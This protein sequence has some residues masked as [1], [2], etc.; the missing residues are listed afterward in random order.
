MRRALF[1]LT[2]LALIGG[3]L[4]TPATAAIKAG[5]TCSKLNQVSVSAGYKYTCIKSG[6]KLV[7]SK[8]V[9]VAVSLPTQSPTAS[10]I[11]SSTSVP[12][13]KPSPTPTPSATPVDPEKLLEAKVNEYWTKWRANLLN[14]D[15]RVTVIVQAGYS[16]KWEEIT[17]SATKYIMKIFEGNGLK[18][19][20]TPY[21]VY[22]D[23][24]EFRK[25]AFDVYAQNAPCHPPYMPNLEEVIYCAIAD[26]GAG[27]LRIGRDGQS[28][29]GGYELTAND[30]KLLNYFIGH[31]MGIFYEA[32]AQYGDSP[33]TGIKD[34]IPSWIREGTA[35]MVGV[36]IT[37]D[38][39]NNQGSYLD[40]IQKVGMLPPKPT[41]ICI[42]DLQ[43]AEGKDKSWPDNCSHGM[44]FY[45]VQLLVANHGGLDALFKFDQ[46]YGT[47]N[48]WPT[49]F[50]ETFGI[51]REDFYR[52]WW[53]YLGIPK[54]NWPEIKP[55][56]PAEHY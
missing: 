3:V 29:T 1:P 26:I 33:Y 25:Q 36:L 45:A 15:P 43:M 31:E 20:Q 18:L 11:P 2:A 22:G 52:E 40:M 10:P 19:V 4:A 27:G 56:T 17:L 5:T 28:M 39:S 7:W 34:Q 32:Q 16:K 12:S 46:T 42:K 55:P 48:D 14:T 35:Q 21:W 51:S 44:N 41:Q 24:E 54:A 30:Q 50:K 47:N 13:P 38:L 53:T 37:N 23:T 6:K 9:K 8:G 49:V